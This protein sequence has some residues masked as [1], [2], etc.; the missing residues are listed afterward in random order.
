MRADRI[1]VDSSKSLGADYTSP[2]V[3][4]EYMYG[5]SVQA[6]WTGSPVGHLTLQMSLD[7]R[8]ANPSLNIA[9]VAGNWDEIDG[10]SAATTGINSF[11]WNVNTA[12]YP[13]VRVHYASDS[14][15]GTLTFLYAFVRGA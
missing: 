10:T 6:I 8:P 4:L 14:G 5:Y 3:N 12:N 15:S 11:S 1:L 9:E 2:P 7:Y 13:W